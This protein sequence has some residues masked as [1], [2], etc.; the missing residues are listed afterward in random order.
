[1]MSIIVFNV[2]L[3]KW[4]TTVW[5]WINLN[6][7]WLVSHVAT[8]NTHVRY[9]L[10]P[11]KKLRYS[12]HW[13]NCRNIQMWEFLKKLQFQISSYIITMWFN[14]SRN[15]SSEG[16][17]VLIFFIRLIKMF[18]SEMF[19]YCYISYYEKQESFLFSSNTWEL[20]FLAPTLFIDTTLNVRIFPK[21]A[22][23][24]NF[25]RLN[26][27]CNFNF[28]HTYIFNKCRNINFNYIHKQYVL[29]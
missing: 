16:N 11:G 9:F 4:S 21:K 13:I 5:I 19:G 25:I 2:D 29:N 23:F 15:W 17:S 1:M 18:S 22:L 6:T 14:S 12:I 7:K 20:S 3:K 26:V 8:T 27:K 28:I 10:K 24:L